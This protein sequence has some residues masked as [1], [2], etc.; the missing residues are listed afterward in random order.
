MKDCCDSKLDEIGCD[1]GR[2]QTRILKIVLAINLIMLGV[3]LAWGIFANSTAL[4]ADSLDMLGDAF[5]YAMSLYVVHRGL[6]AKAKVSLVKGLIMFALAAVIFGEALRN[7]IE[8]SSPRP[9]VM[10]VIGVAA[11]IANLLCLKLLFRHRK[12]DL[13]MQST[14]L[15]SR[16]D[17]LANIGVLVAALLVHLFESNIP[18]LIVGVVIAIII[19]NSSWS[20][21]RRA[22]QQIRMRETS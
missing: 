20:V 16:N 6:K 12:D 21:I 19:L 1:I 8:G 22:I 9:D 5:V 13:N 7:Y 15:C 14:W 2:G 10:G 11:L 4:L 3:E 18:D 17:I